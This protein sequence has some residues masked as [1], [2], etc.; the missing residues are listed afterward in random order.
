MFQ[1]REHLIEL[2]PDN[3]KLLELLQSAVY[4]ISLDDRSPATLDEVNCVISCCFR[5]TVYQIIIA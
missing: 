5:F 3:G 1:L 4:C 2:H